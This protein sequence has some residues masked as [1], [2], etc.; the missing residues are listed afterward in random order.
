MGVPLGHF[1]PFWDTLK[2]R[3]SRCGRPQSDTEKRKEDE[4]KMIKRKATRKDFIE[5]LSNS[6]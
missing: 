2:T 6:S 3:K 4:K 1:C 5:N